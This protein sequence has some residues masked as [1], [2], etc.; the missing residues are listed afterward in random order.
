MDILFGERKATT[1]SHNGYSVRKKSI[2][3][4]YVMFGE[5][6]TTVSFDLLKHTEIN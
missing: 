5:K 3:Y 6:N 1:L 2:C 4:S